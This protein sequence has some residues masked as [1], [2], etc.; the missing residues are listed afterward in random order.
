MM[1]TLTGLAKRHPLFGFLALAY[2]LSWWPWLWVRLDPG[3]IDG[4]IL[5]FGPLPAAAVMLAL[6]GGWSAVRAWLGKI[7]EWRVGLLWYALA[8]LLPAAITAMA[9][10]V[11]LFLG[12]ELPPGAELP[13]WGDLA[14]RFVIVFLVVGLGE[15]PAWRGYALPRLIAG[16]T[17]LAGALMLGLLHALWHLPLYG[18]DYDLANLW[19][20]LA[21]VLAV[22][23]VTAWMWLATRGNLLLP[24]LLHAAA[25]TVAF[26]WDWFTG[27][28][29]L[30][31]WWIWAGLWVAAAA[32]VVIIYGAAL[33]R[34]K[35]RRMLG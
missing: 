6:S 19:P 22:S 1:A 5:P 23:V 21:S 17:A 31:L 2:A 30:R 11:N 9:V 26:P 14:Q 25:N 33:Y 12:A 8:L 18:V 24:A 34:S 28:E 32:I 20:W 16:R 29:Q 35:P 15:E 27:D 4:P 13:S 7:A 3:T 10:G